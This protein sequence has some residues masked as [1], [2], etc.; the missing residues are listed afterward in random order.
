MRNNHTAVLDTGR[1]QRNYATLGR[2][3]PAAVDNRTA[4]CAL[5]IEVVIASHEIFIPY[6][7][8]GRHQTADVHHR[9]IAEQDTIGIDQH[10]SP[11][12]GQLT[13]NVG[14]SVTIDT[15]ESY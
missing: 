7:N 9:G 12:G 2:S 14:W 1:N 11:V 10:Y 13:E 4:R 3:D 5:D 15:V 6:V 8:R